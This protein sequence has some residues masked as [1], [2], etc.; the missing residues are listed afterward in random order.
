MSAT[1]TAF[2]GS[3]AALGWK[4]AVVLAAPPVFDNIVLELRTEASRCVEI[5][6]GLLPL[7]HP[8]KHA[9]AIW[10]ELRVTVL[11]QVSNASESRRASRWHVSCFPNHTW[12]RTPETDLFARRIPIPRP[13]C[14]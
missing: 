2:A 5:F 4:S 7:S 10:V 1:G 13:K 11:A 9:K 14:S 12:S 6:N 8:Q 3:C